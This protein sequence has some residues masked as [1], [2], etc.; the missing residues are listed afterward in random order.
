MNDAKTAREEAKMYQ[1]ERDSAV[2]REKAK[3]AE[4]LKLSENILNTAHNIK[5]PTTALGIAMA[6]LDTPPTSCAVEQN[7]LI[8]L[9]LYH[10]LLNDF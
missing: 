7:P 2:E 5:S 3:E 10:T 9:P 8:R 4:A 1:V 6:F